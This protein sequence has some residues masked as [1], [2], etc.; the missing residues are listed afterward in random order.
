MSKKQSLTSVEGYELPENSKDI[1][2]AD[3]VAPVYLIPLS[4][5]QIVEHEEWVENEKFRISEQE[6]NIKNKEKAKQSALEKLGKL[7]LTKEEAKS[8]VGI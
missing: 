7:G 6:K 4:D 2:P 8:I 5:E 3:S 1:T